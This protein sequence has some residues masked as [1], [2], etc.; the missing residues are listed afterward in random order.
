MDRRFGPAPWGWNI[1][2]NF[3]ETSAGALAG[4]TSGDGLWLVFPDSTNTPALHFDRTNGLPSDWVIS[5][6]EDRE[7]NLW[8]GTGA[9]LVV[10]RPNNLETI[11]PPDKWKSC[12][13]LSVLPAP[14]GAL[15]VGTEG[16]GLYRLQNGDWTN[17]DPA[18]GIRNPYVWS[19]AADGAG[20]I[21][22]G[23]WGGG[24][25]AQKD[26]AFDFAPGLENFLFADAG[27][28]VCGR[29]TL[30][31]HAGGRA[32]LS[33]RKT[34]AVQRNCRPAVRRRAR[35]RAG[36]IGRAVVRH[37]GRRPGA[38]AKWKFPPV[39]KVRRAVVRFHRV[40]AFRGRRRA[41]DRHVRRRA[42]PVQGRKIF[43]DQS[44]TGFAQ[45]RHRPH[46][47]G[48]ARIFLDEFLRRHFARERKGFEPLR[49]RR[50][51]RGA[52]P[53]LRHQ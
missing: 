46:R 22:A 21:W 4:G 8:C 41:V 19:L 15:W 43:R 2:A 9:G 47:S 30:D 16:A 11:S 13:V 6:W 37:G 23:T 27:A 18:Q 38:F 25:F 31:R 5:L 48:R 49:R 45:R 40:P 44:R 33:K 10:I 28:F 1:V 7:K 17:F 39:Q 32:V 14:D 51:R 12:P 29:R 3:L 34:G 53:D 35:H 20:K 36:Q 52:V 42:G 24:L 26:D 50:N